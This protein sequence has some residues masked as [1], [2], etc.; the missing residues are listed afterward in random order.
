MST[1]SMLPSL[2]HLQAATG[3]A[4][5]GSRLRSGWYN[6]AKRRCFT[7]NPHLKAWWLAG[8]T[9]F[10]TVKRFSLRSHARIWFRGKEMGVEVHRLRL[11]ITN[12]YL[13]K[14]E[15]L[16]LVDAGPSQKTELLRRRLQALSI[17]PNDVSL[18]VLTHAHWDHVAS[19][20]EWKEMTGCKVAVNNCERE[21]VEKALSPMPKAFSPWGR[22]F[23][24]FS[25][26]LAATSHSSGTPVD[27]TLQDDGIS[28]EPFGI[29]GKVLH[30]PGHTRGSMSVLLDNGDA[31]V[32]DLAMNGLPP[33][34]RPGMPF[35]GDD[36]IAVKMSW[37]LLLDKGAKKMYPAHGNPFD[38][39]VLRKKL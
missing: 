4:R 9:G 2:F 31:F 19:L 20:G 5:C 27:L 21:W 30:T 28:L 37:R 13:I 18:I 15:G 7:S 36:P 12:C 25:G 23:I 14:E 11:G 33:R 10:A 22:L 24:L 39:S 3:R 1:L 16:I 38:A 35:L 6:A 32:G 26:I 8:V 34:F 29:S 17:S